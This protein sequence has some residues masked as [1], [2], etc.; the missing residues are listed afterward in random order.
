MFGLMYGIESGRT[1]LRSQATKEHAGGLKPP[2]AVVETVVSGAFIHVFL[3]IDCSVK[4]GTYRR[5]GHF[6]LIKSDP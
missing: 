6:P 2:V 5:R 1:F 3:R 4:I